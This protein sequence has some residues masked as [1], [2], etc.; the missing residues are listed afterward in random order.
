MA[1]AGSAGTANDLER[2]GQKMASGAKAAGKAVAKAATGNVAGAAVDVASN[3]SAVMALLAP[4]IAIIVLVSLLLVIVLY[5]FPM[6]IDEALVDL[7]ENGG[8]IFEEAFLSSGR[9]GFLGVVEG[10]IK[11]I[12]KWLETFF[13]VFGKAFKEILI[14]TNQDKEFI[15]LKNGATEF[16]VATDYDKTIPTLTQKLEMVQKKF[17][18]RVAAIESAMKGGT[19]P[20]MREAKKHFIEHYNNTNNA[21]TNF[22]TITTTEANEDEEKRTTAVSTVNGNQMEVKWFPAYRVDRMP[23]KLALQTAALYDVMF[24]NDFPLTKISDFYR[25]LGYP[26]AN[27]GDVL[28]FKIFDKY[29]KTTGWTGT[30]MP[31]YLVDEAKFYAKQAGEKAKQ[32]YW[33]DLKENEFYFYEIYGNVSAEEAEKIQKEQA[34]KAYNKAYRKVYSVYYDKY[35]VSFIDMMISLHT[36]KMIIT[37]QL[38]PDAINSNLMKTSKN[39]LGNYEL[40]LKIKRNGDTGAPNADGTLSHYNGDDGNKPAETV[41]DDSLCNYNGWRYEGVAEYLDRQNRASGKKSAAA[42]CTESEFEEYQNAYNG[43]G[44]TDKYVEFVSEVNDDLLESDKKGGKQTHG[45]YVEV[46]DS[47]QKWEEAEGHI[48]HKEEN[49]ARTFQVESRTVT[50]ITME[51]DSSWR[52]RYYYTINGERGSTWTNYWADSSGA[53]EAFR[54]YGTWGENPITYGAYSN[55]ERINLEWEE[56]EITERQISQPRVKAWFYHNTYKVTYALPY[57]I[58]PRTESEIL[59]FAGLMEGDCSEEYRQY[60]EDIKAYYNTETAKSLYDENPFDGAD[61]IDEYNA[62]NQDDYEIVDSGKNWDD[63]GPDESE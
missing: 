63:V 10:T 52:W 21:V 61:T 7:F 2:S 33:D 51:R 16:G 62:E 28:K 54:E 29:K 3:P 48:V 50:S 14:G 34:E 32:K 31:Q 46:N 40:S 41:N 44:L 20:L 59:N 27:G 4:V 18:L 36:G 25:W 11:G 26:K 12:A 55:A 22:F 53:A 58:G 42:D 1:Y 35:G 5:V 6:E 17:E 19:S 38:L 30:F 45:K 15:E 37:E 60:L 9:S 43:G 39:L 49:A 24:D 56:L 23:D 8:D 13:D 47:T 57:Y